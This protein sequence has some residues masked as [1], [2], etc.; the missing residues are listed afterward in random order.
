[1]ARRVAYV[2]AFPVIFPLRWWRALQHAAQCMPDAMSPAIHLHVPLL[3]WADSVGEVTGYLLGTGHVMRIPLDPAD[4][5]V[6][7]WLPYSGWPIDE[8]VLSSFYASR[9]VFGLPDLTQAQGV[10]QASAFHGNGLSANSVAHV[11]PTDLGARF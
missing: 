11:F 10:I 5:Q 1:L 7:P 6:R 3:L 2:G 4:F 9:E 8:S